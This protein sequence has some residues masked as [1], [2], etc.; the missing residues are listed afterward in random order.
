MSIHLGCVN[1]LGFGSVWKQTSLLNGL[2]SHNFHV[3][4][5][6]KSE[7]SDPHVFTPFLNGY[8]K[9]IVKGGS[10]VVLHKEDAVLQIR[11]V[12]L[13]TECYWSWMQCILLSKSLES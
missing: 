12:F 8:E 1:V 9:F 2:R 10:V 7:L 11:P 4:I 3:C 13:D 5:I 6:T